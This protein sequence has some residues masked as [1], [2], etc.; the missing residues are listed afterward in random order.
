MN[1]VSTNTS[2]TDVRIVKIYFKIHYITQYG[3]AIYLCGDDEFLGMWD[4]CKA[5]RL[6]WN[7]N[8]EWTIC[9]KMP[10]IARKFEY[11]FLVN[12][13]NE[14][15]IHKAYWEPGENRIITKH[16]LL[17]GRKSEYFNQEF[18]GYRTIKLKLNHTL[19]PKERMMIIGSIP[20]IGSWKS[21]VLMKQQLKIDILTQEPIQQWSISFIVNPLNFFFRYYYV[22]RNDETGNMIWE[23][24]NGRYLKTADLSSIRQVLDQYD[25]HP[26]KVKTQIYTAFQARQ[27]HK[28]GS[29]S[30]S[31]IPKSKIKQNNQGYSFADKEPSFFYYEEFGRLNKLDWN[32]VVQFQTYEINENILIGPYPQNE[33]D[34]LYLKQ[35]QVRAVLNLQTRLDMFH[36]GVNWEQ[37]V[38]AYKRHNIVMKN[39]QIFDMDSEDF[40]KKSNKA[41]QILK[42]L[43]NEYEYVYVHCTAGIGRAPS[44][45]VLYLAS[46]LQYDLK[47]AIEFVKQKRQQFYIN[48]SMLKKSFQKTLVFNHGLGYQDLTQTL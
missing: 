25:L 7:Q 23:R 44:I 29:F 5:L 48:Y 41:V 43:I 37:I 20:E 3:Q 18:W 21:P 33:Q 14:P 36:R 2:F 35:K 39:Y 19:Q 16:L 40:E 31:K 12:D 10:R 26:I 42:K 24:G 38:D 15:S 28:N 30:S 17:N 47:E 27:I 22:I 46:I 11:K 34:I 1:S 6:Q 8:N 32:F 13:Y 45:V 9:V 4:P